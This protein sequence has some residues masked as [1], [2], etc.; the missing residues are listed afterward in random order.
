M[1]L[2]NFWP[3]TWRFLFP[4]SS[5]IRFLDLELITSNTQCAIAN[6]ELLVGDLKCDVGG[7]AFNYPDFMLVVSKL[8]RLSKNDTIFLGVTLEICLVLAFFFLIYFFCI[9]GKIEFKNVFLAASVLFS[10][11]LIFVLER[12]N[13][14]SLVF[15]LT[16]LGLSLLDLSA[17]TGVS[18]IIFSYAL[19]LYPAAAVLILGL[20]KK[21]R[22]A[23]LLIS[24]LVIAT[25]G[26]LNFKDFKR[27][28]SVSP[29]YQWDS[30]G[31]RVIP[32]Q[33]SE[34]FSLNLRGRSGLVISAISG[35]LLLAVFT[36]VII[37]FISRFGSVRKMAA[38]DVDYLF[39]SGTNREFNVVVGSLLVFLAAYFVGLSWDTKLI[40]LIPLALMVTFKSGGSLFLK[41][42]I[43]IFIWTSSP[44]SKPIQTLGDFFC[45]LLVSYLLIL[46]LIYF[47]QRLKKI[48]LFKSIAV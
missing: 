8:L 32:F 18:F 3:K 29:Q 30:F 22:F 14:D 23:A 16:L 26:C 28:W 4:L 9:D 34:Y 2:T 13:S 10:P 37:F 27:V 47:L 19:K 39:S 5:N 43:H 7:R 33:L 38:N 35:F 48:N 17:L 1:I 36:C 25:W 40:F 11:P 41:S 21:P 42:S 31:L 46:L 45:M 44:I 6:P 20:M 15:F 24:S 12:G